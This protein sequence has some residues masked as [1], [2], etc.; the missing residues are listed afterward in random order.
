[1]NKIGILI[2][3]IFLLISCNENVDIITDHESVIINNS[4]YNKTTTSNYTITEAILNE[5][6][7]TLKIS[8]SGCD[9]NSWKAVLIDANIVLESYPVQRNIKLSL[10]N[11]EACLA[12]F[13]QEYTFDISNLKEGYS[14]IILNLEGWNTQIN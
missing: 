12:F 9:G 7:L 3:M 14:D 1:M 10:D 4:L 2:T 6:L 11:N 5:N 8:S 13:E